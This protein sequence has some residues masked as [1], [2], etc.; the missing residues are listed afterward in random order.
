MNELAIILSF[1]HVPLFETARALNEFVF[2]LE[3]ITGN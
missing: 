3:I 2:N 1:F